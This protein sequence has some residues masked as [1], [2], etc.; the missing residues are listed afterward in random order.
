MV[1]AEELLASGAIAT[2]HRV[3]PTASSSNLDRV[4]M[5]YLRADISGKKTPKCKEKKA[6]QLGQK[7]LE[8]L[9][10]LSQWLP[11]IIEGRMSVFFLEKCHLLWGDIC[12]YI[13]AAA[14]VG[15]LP[16]KTCLGKS[17]TRTCCTHRQRGRSR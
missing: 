1:T 3:T 16:P 5:S 10:Q 12:A 2:A 8:I 15:K 11:E 4:T 6:T 14:N 17:N 9:A 13:W 7:K